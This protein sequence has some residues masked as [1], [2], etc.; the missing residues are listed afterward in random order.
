TSFSVTLFWVVAI[1]LVVFYVNRHCHDIWYYATAKNI[2]Q[3]VL[4][5]GIT[6]ILIFAFKAVVMP[7]VLLP[8]SIPVLDAILTV[9]FIG[10]LRLSLRFFHDEIRP[11]FANRDC[12]NTLLVGA[13]HEGGK[14]AYSIHS[15]PDLGF[16]IIG[17]ITIHPEKVKMLL[18]NIPVLGHLDDI[19]DVVKKHRVTDILVIA[20]ILSGPKMRELSIACK[21]A[22][23]NLRIV[24]QGDTRLGNR[25]I[26][27]RDINIDDLLKRDPIRLDDSKIRE[28]VQGRRVLV[29]GGGGSIGS[30]ICRQL[31]RFHPENLLILGRGENRIFFLERELNELNY[32]TGITPIIADVTNADRMNNVFDEFRPEVVFHAAAHKHVPLMEANVSEAIRNNIYGTKVVADLADEYETKTFVLVSTDKAVNPTS[33]MGTTKHIAERYVHTMS[34]VSSTRFIVTRFGNVL[35][36]AGSVVPIF[37]E[38]IKLGGP[39]T[40]TDERMTRFFMTIPEAS[41]LVLQA[42]AMGNGGEIFVLDMGDPVKIV[43]L[44]KDMIRLA[45]LPEN[46]IE[47]RF[48]GLRPGEKLYEELYFDSETTLETAHPKLRAAQHRSFPID[49]VRKQIDTLCTLL[50]N[51][52]QTDL[53]HCLKEYV[54][55]YK[56]F[57]DQADVPSDASSAIITKDGFTITNRS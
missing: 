16:K 18:G 45:G 54:P 24:P 28:L 40:I 1:K 8:R 12:K 33:I 17:F 14:L 56:P 51:V 35:G 49:V 2:Q 42:A 46:A 44:A 3:L 4:S 41:Q 48:T 36:S 6:G 50:D 10:G 5:A 38:Q 43:D 39:I 29:T 19:Q 13:N 15:Y 55:E 52:S 22:G 21:S 31:I 25:S 23:L 34:Q 27:I 47:I 9:C 32:C 20:G 11:R 26:P 7:E 30:E 53:R 37:R 57:Q